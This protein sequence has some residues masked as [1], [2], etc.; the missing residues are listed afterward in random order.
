[1]VWGPD[2]WE[3]SG[4]G[5]LGFGHSG[6]SWFSP[7]VKAHIRWGLN[8]GPYATVLS[9]RLARGPLFSRLFTSE[10]LSQGLFLG[11]PQLRPPAKHIEFH[12][13]VLPAALFR[14]DP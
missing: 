6:P 10:S 12:K 7:D 5:N 13:P 4:A 9:F 2:L 8:C 11:E 3:Q 1:M 14:A